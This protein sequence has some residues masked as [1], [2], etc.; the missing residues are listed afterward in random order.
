MLATKCC[1][2]R[3]FF[4]LIDEKNL[5]RLRILAPDSIAQR[6]LHQSSA[7][8]G[9]GCCGWDR[10]KKEGAN[11]GRK[12]RKRVRAETVCSFTVCWRNHDWKKGLLHI[13]LISYCISKYC[14]D[15]RAS[16]ES[17]GKLVV[18]PDSGLIA[19]LR[20]CKC[21]SVASQSNGIKQCN[22]QRAYHQRFAFSYITSVRKSNVD[23][24]KVIILRTWLQISIIDH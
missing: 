3:K 5:W 23:S 19:A 8:L 11:K 7:E 16:R 17:N 1:H 22:L 24:R 6:R 10:S 21:E 20:V 4:A 9:R 18:S 13:R 15:F 12:A 2:Q 14:T